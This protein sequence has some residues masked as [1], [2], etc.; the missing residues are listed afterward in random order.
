MA[1]T[2]VLLG[3]VAP[4]TAGAAEAYRLDGKRTTVR[5]YSATLNEASLPM[6]SVT[7]APT[8]PSPDDCTP[9]SCDLRELRLALPRGTSSGVF[10]AALS[11][12]VTMAAAV[13]LYDSEGTYVAGA[14]AALLDLT[15]NCCGD[16]PLRYTLKIAKDRV[17]AGRYTIAIVNR[18]GTGKVD[19]TVTW[20]AHPPDRRR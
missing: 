7:G 10:T 20:H 11:V 6:R 17:P 19:A 9:G 1:V 16:D 15:P 2:A 14:D 12:P 3:L 5:K 13:V 4:A 18:G 8:T